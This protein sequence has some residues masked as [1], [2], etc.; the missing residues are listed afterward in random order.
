MPGSN[1]T[2]SARYWPDIGNIN[3]HV[4]RE[5]WSFYTKISAHICTFL[6]EENTIKTS[7]TS[8]N[9]GG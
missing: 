8:G 4:G 9:W 6:N 7:K 5:K 1:Y 3:K 2:T